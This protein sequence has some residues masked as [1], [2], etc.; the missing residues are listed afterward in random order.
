MMY[1]N[2][3]RRSFETAQFVVNKQSYRTSRAAP[4]MKITSE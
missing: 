1:S 2:R 3:Y 4:A